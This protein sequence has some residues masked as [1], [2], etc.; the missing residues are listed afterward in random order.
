MDTI[1][2]DIPLVSVA[3]ITFNHELYISD[4]LSSILNQDT[5]FEFEIIIGDDSSEDATQK[6]IREYQKHSSNKISSILRKKNIGG[7]N[8]FI[9]VL[10]LCKGKYIA[11]CEGDDYWLSKFKLQ[12]QVDFLEKNLG[13]SMSFHNANVFHYDS[14]IKNTLFCET[15]M[16]DVINTYDLIRKFNIPT[17]SIVFRKSCL[18]IPEWFKYV[19]N[20]DYALSLM[21]SQQG[22]IKYFDD[23]MSVYR[24]NKGG[25]NAKMKNSFILQKKFELLSFF[26][27]YTEFN[28][29]DAIQ[30]RKQ[31]I[32][33]EIPFAIENEKDSIEKLFTPAFYKRRFFK[34]SR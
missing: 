8:N 6:I 24:K 5:N 22:K 14:K 7:I 26:D 3:I 34:N 9:D 15:Q 25:L 17:A 12:K 4:A 33:H 11:L 1:V 31:L 27:Y 29:H 16:L 10:N 28:F 19:Y 23:V 2:Q 20:G 32:I 18:K 21:L 30:S 13:F